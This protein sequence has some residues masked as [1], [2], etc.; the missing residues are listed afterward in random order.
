MP[1]IT[2]PA[3]DGKGGSFQRFVCQVTSLGPC[4][5][6]P[7][8]VF[9]I[10]SDARNVCL[11]RGKRKLLEQDE[12]RTLLQ[13]LQNYFAPERVYTVYQDV[14]QLPHSRKTAQTINECSAEFDLICRKAVGHTRNGDAFPAAFMAALS[15]R[16]ASVT[17]TN[18]RSLRASAML[19]V[20]RQM[21]RLFGP[22]GSAGNQIF[23][24][25]LTDN[26]T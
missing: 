17:T 26:R 10:D 14:A 5:R 1:A 21:R 16:N 11:A 13:I 23:S 2:A 3:F 7:A 22:L 18:P 12:I 6:A 19:E 25:S 20:A 9:Q 15:L 24:S 8:R 4:K